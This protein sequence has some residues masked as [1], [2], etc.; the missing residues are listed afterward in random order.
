MEQVILS[1][2][3]IPHLEVISPITGETKAQVS[4]ASITHNIQRFLLTTDVNLLFIK[5]E[6]II[7]ILSRHLRQDLLD[8]SKDA[9]MR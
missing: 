2:T 9:S 7:P 3:G 8:G 5:H 4:N 1:I 6:L